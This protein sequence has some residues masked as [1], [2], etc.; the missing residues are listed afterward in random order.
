[1]MMAL[2]HDA[3]DDGDD[4]NGDDGD[5]DDGDGADSDGADEHLLGGQLFQG[6]QSSPPKIHKIVPIKASDFYQV[7]NG[8][9]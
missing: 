1:M 8:S 2:V 7:S 4:G 6:R 9:I 3:Y 5:S